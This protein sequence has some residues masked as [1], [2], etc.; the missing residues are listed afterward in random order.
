[1]CALP[2]RGDELARYVKAQVHELGHVITDVVSGT[3]ADEMSGSAIPIAAVEDRI[4][5][6][7][8]ADTPLAIAGELFRQN[9]RH[10]YRSHCH[11]SRR[12]RLASIAE[13]DDRVKAFTDARHERAQVRD[14]CGVDVDADQRL[15]VITHQRDV[16]G[17][18]DRGPKGEDA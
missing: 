1:V 3:A 9:L 11:D 15:V 17:G 10:F 18:A 6:S 7:Q 16:G 8:A 4:A 5:G 13:G 14:R 12:S 2:P